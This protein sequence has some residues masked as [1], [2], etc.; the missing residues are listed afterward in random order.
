MISEV[1]TLVEINLGYAYSNNRKIL[2][3][4]STVDKIIKEM[5]N[6]IKTEL[7]EEAQTVEVVEYIV[8][9]F[10][11]GIKEYPLKL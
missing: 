8:S 6:I 7:P 9:K 4:N 11:D 2:L 1:R 5:F 10:K 3:Q